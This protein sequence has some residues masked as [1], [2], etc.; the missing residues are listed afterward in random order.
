MKTRKEP[1]SHLSVHCYKRREHLIGATPMSVCCCYESNDGTD[2]GCTTYLGDTCPTIAGY[3]LVSSSTGPCSTLDS[4][5]SEENGNYLIDKIRSAAATVRVAVSGQTTFSCYGNCGRSTE[6]STFRFP[7]SVS[8]YRVG[9]VTG[10]SLREHHLLNAT[11][12]EITYGPASGVC[13]DHISPYVGYVD[14]YW[15][16]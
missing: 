5:M 9:E 13:S 8:R 16:S 11:T 12:L 10:V 15:D 4:K 7:R 14:V 3:K 1:C 6:T 2:A